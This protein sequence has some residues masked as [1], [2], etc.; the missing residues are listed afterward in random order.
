MRKDMFKKKEPMTII[1]NYILF[2]L[3]KSHTTFLRG[4]IV[5]RTCHSI[6]KDTRDYIPI[7][8]LL[9][10]ERAVVCKKDVGVGDGVPRNLNT[11]LSYRKYL[12]LGKKFIFFINS[13]AS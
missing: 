7:L 4:T 12:I 10:R 2:F 9:A 5:N 3:N 1:K 8:S 11:R 6:R 13:P